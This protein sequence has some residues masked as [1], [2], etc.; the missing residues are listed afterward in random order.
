M[1]YKLRLNS[2]SPQSHNKGGE[3]T[4]FL[5]VYGITPLVGIGGY[6]ILNA[7]VG[8]GFAGDLAPAVTR[9]RIYMEITCFHY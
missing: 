1:F 7:Q 5:K 4:I 8:Q 6:L 2:L 9:I 3:V